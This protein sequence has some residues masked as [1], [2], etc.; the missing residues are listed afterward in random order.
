MVFVSACQKCPSNQLSTAVLRKSMPQYKTNHLSN[1][2]NV[3]DP[4]TL[5][6]YLRKLCAF[7]IAARCLRGSLN[8]FANHFTVLVVCAQSDRTPPGSNMWR[9]NVCY[10]AGTYYA[11]AYAHAVH[12]N[13]SGRMGAQSVASVMMLRQQK[14]HRLKSIKLR[15]SHASQTHRKLSLAGLFLRVCV[16]SRDSCTRITRG[17]GPAQPRNWAIMPWLRR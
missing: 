3:A 14:T 9:T 4:R 5:S 2:N 12:L 7:N 1:G 16:Y 10:A 17:T 15:I 11:R 6:A 13:A 8:R